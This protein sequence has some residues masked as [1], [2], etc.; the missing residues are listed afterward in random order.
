MKHTK[1]RATS[2]KNFRGLNSLIISNPATERAKQRLSA[3]ISSPKQ[4]S[5]KQS[6]YHLLHPFPSLK[7]IP[8]QRKNVL[9][10]LYMMIDHIAEVPPKNNTITPTFFHSQTPPS[11]ARLNLVGVI[12]TR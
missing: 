11:P 5:A 6:S 4:T 10:K 1:L 3:I 8:N 7:V 12:L 9:Y 2:E